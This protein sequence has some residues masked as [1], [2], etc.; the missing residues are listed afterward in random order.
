MFEAYLTLIIFTVVLLGT[1][2]PATLAVA[3]TGTVF[4]FRQGVLFTAGL[5]VG[6]GVVLVLESWGLSRLL[7][8]YPELKFYL[9]WF[10]LAYVI[11]LAFKI[12][13][14]KPV[15]DDQP[16]SRAPTFFDGLILNISNPKAYAAVLVIYTQFLLPHSDPQL[17]YA[18]TGMVCFVMVLL[19]D[20]GWLFLGQMLRPL[21]KQPKR[22][23]IIRLVFAT[24]MILAMLFMM[25]FVDG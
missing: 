6:F 4:G 3:A 1:P 11:F 12:A 15:T 18:M 13:T 22:A 5:V 24:S 10:G 16:S 19:I 25:F 2:G 8:Q 23:Q 7:S 14:A 21:F 20:F 17:A 9:Q